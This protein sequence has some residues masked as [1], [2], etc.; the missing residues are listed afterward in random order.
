MT[1]T[2]LIIIIGVLVVTLIGVITFVLLKK[3]N[4]RGDVDEMNK[5]SGLQLLLQQMNE[6]SRTVDA[7]LSES[8]KITNETIRHQTN[9]S[10]NIIREVTE[11]LTELKESNKQV[12]SFTDQ[13]QSLQ[14]N[15]KNPKQRGILGEYYLETLLKN[16][17]PPGS[18]QM[19]YAFPD[20]DIVDAVVFVKDKIIP[21]DS[22][23]SLENYN[24]ISETSDKT[25]K[26]R[27]EKVFVNDLKNRITETSKY[28]QPEQNTMDFA[29]MFIP[30]EAIYYDLLINKIGAVLDDTE[31]L[32]QRAASKYRVLIVSPTSF[33][34]YLQTVLQGLNALQIEETAKDI[35]KRVDDLGKHLKSYEEYH[36][37]LGNALSTTVN[38]YT[39]SGKAFKQIDKDILKDTGTSI[40]FEPLVLE[41]PAS[42]E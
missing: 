30:H 5:D 7:K 32:I 25:E 2:I 12:M 21:I 15:L 1:T 11:H 10:H 20:G 29:F 27:L 16:I 38:H 33:L 6:L 31:T 22:K 19:Q 9:Q 35:V 36:M 37:K 3:G 28:I 23:F 42:D 17:L 13:L 24:R 8:Q 39:A 18:Y 4:A 40:G 14:D 34:A 26:D 41:R